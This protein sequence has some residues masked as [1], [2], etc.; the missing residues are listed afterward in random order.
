MKNYTI[1]LF[2]F[3]FLNMNSQV[4]NGKKNTI[5]EFYDAEIKQIIIDGGKV[6]AQLKLKQYPRK[7]TRNGERSSVKQDAIFIDLGLTNTSSFLDFRKLRLKTVGV[8]GGITYQHSFSKLLLK[9]D[10]SLK[11]DEFRSFIFSANVSTD[12]FDNFDPVTGEIDNESPTN[13]SVRGGYNKYY[14]KE[15][16]TFIR[17]LN[18]KVNI[19]DSNADELKNFLDESNTTNTQGV[20]VDN[21]GFFDGKFGTVE[22]DRRSTF[23]S[24]AVPMIFNKKTYFGYL[25][26]IPHLSWETFNSNSPRYS[27]GVS[28]GFLAKSIIGDK[29]ET[30]KEGS[31]SY[32]YKK[33]NAPSFLSIGIDW[34]NQSGTGSK[35]NYFITGSYKF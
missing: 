31:N 13:L 8:T 23:L 34:N 5:A 25:T 22:N 11:E 29:I 32:K 6:T 33:F 12:R 20:V 28:L 4:L 15:K 7:F 19:V 21:Q 24:L 26:P 1:I 17:A 9:D 30:L 10:E 2:L 27:A 3:Y 16:I 18:F 14:F 35:P